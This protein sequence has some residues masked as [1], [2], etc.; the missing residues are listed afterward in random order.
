MELREHDAVLLKSKSKNSQGKPPVPT[1]ITFGTASRA[2]VASSLVDFVPRGHSGRAA[3][4]ASFIKSET[5]LSYVIFC[6][7][8]KAT[9]K[10]ETAHI[11][12]G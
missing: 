9:H 10:L 6:S 4:G 11:S 12:K 2:V 5:H 1:S 8:G 7:K 3:A